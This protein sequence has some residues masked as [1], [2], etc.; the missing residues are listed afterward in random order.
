MLS[1]EST[2]EEEHDKCAGERGKIRDNRASP[3]PESISR[4]DNE[5]G[6]ERYWGKGSEENK[7]EEDSMT[8]RRISLQ[9]TR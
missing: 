2:R 1:K 7:E 5:C 3:G 6:V 8:I 4:K 9:P